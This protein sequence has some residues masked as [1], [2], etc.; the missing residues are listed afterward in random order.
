MDLYSLPMLHPVGARPNSVGQYLNIPVKQDYELWDM[1][2]RNNVPVVV[3]PPNP[4]PVV[5]MVQP[6]NSSVGNAL[7]KGVSELKNA[8]GGM[9][10][11]QKFSTVGGAL[12]G[13]YGA[14]NAHKQLGLA[15]DQLNFNKEQYYTNLNNQRKMVNS[16]LE[17]RQRRRVAQAKDGGTSTTSVGEYMAK[18]G[19]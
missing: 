10:G 13:L 9:N 12:A 7:N 19:V 18:Y 1:S 17:D 11:Y 2:A 14:Y 8:W 3:T 5:E 15:K 4:T 6:T 16:Q